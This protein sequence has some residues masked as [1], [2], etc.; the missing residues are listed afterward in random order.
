M[1]ETLVVVGAVVVLIAAGLIAKSALSSN[2]RM[3]A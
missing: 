3:A 1:V 2:R